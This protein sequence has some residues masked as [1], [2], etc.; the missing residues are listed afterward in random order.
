MNTSCVTKW[1]L[2]LNSTKKEKNL[3]HIVC[4][5]LFVQML[6][7]LPGSLGYNRDGHSNKELLVSPILKSYVLLLVQRTAFSSLSPRNT[8]LCECECGCICVNIIILSHVYTQFIRFISRHIWQP[9]SLYNL[10]NLLFTLKIWEWILS[11][12]MRILHRH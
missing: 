1:P 9:L 4:L 10:H 7:S 2:V 5:L 3:L 8:T 6:S 12:G 11:I